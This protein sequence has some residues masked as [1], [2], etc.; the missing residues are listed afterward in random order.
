MTKHTLFLLLAA[1]L[2]VS[3]C[4]SCEPAADPD[5]GNGQQQQDNPDD[6]GLKPGTY[7]FE[8]SPLKGSW[9][10]GDKIYVHG[11][12]GSWSEVITLEASDISADGK[13]ANGTLGEV[14]GSPGGPDGL[15]AAW[16][17]ESVK[18]IN[19]KLGAKTNFSDC[20]GLITAA[21]LKGDTF[22]FIDVSSVLSFSVSGDYDSYAL[23]AGNR[24]GMTV[25]HFTVEYTS[26]GFATE[27][28]QNTGYP[29]KYGT[30]EP[31][32][33]IRIW[34]PGEMTF[35]GGLFLYLGKDGQWPAVYSSK[36][37][38]TLTAGKV[39][40]LGDISSSLTPY[41]GPAPKMPEKGKSTK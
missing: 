13:T 37:D 1:L 29:F 14:T 12:M 18:H 34:L 33:E 40:D 4:P 28:K 32:K 35:T 2:S 3:V 23:C 11:N 16:P 36:G 31:G 10:A 6:E 19:S 41:D 30:I 24:D 20:D 9:S 22:S 8:A 17:D 25:T 27:Q 26:S 39:R 21:Y 5:N 38:F 15:Y 7:K